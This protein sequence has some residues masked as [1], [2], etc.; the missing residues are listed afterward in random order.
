MKILIFYAIAIEPIKV[1]TCSASQNDRLNLS[2]VKDTY[3]NAEKM[4]RKF[5]LIEEN[6]ELSRIRLAIHEGKYASRLEGKACK[7]FCTCMLKIL[8]QKL[9]IFKM[10]CLKSCKFCMWHNW[11][12][13]QSLINSYIYAI[14]ISLCLK[15]FVL[16]C[17]DIDN[18]EDKISI[19]RTFRSMQ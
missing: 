16:L 7:C 17:I 3:G 19:L 1:Q 11:L 8:Y 18:R 5:G 6:I 4:A 13:I 14:L 9:F 15:V 2:F 10:N 12:D